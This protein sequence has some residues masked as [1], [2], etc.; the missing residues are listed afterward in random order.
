MPTKDIKNEGLYTGSG[1]K[2]LTSLLPGSQISKSDERVRAIGAI[3]EA[4]ASLGLVRA[5]TECPI[6]KEKLVRIQKTLRT[7]A[8]GIRDP[9]GGRYVF[10][11][12]EIDFLE[13]DMKAMAEKLPETVG[14]ELPGGGE[15]SARLSAASATVRAAERELIAMDKRYAAQPTAKQYI[16]RLSSYLD[17]AAEY[18]N[19]LASKANKKAVA[20]APTPAP[21]T[22]A[23]NESVD[24]LVSAVLSRLGASGAL[25]L[26]RAV[27]L[28]E[29][30]EEYARSI[31]KNIVAAV[32]N[33]E[34]NP[35]AVHVMDGA[36]LVSYEV[37]VKK[38]YTAVAVKMSTMELSVL[39]QP[40]NTF[41]GLQALDKLVIFGGGVP[42]KAGDTIIGG[43][44][45]SGGTGEEEHAIWVYSLWIFPT[46]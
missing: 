23:A 28:I 41:Y 39:C 11:V 6:F 4:V 25:D 13:E 1:D 42:L 12:E 2:G 15:Q 35:I 44:G 17:V 38:A 27:K 34:G 10:S 19:Y 37:A 5:V 21:L 14:A 22:G 36:F 40:G 26:R 30:V 29:A 9:R 18:S 43:L 33:A 32:V 45:I 3:E 46:L 8:E 31:G 20:P 16:N 24:S 7:L